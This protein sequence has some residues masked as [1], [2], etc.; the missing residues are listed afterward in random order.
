MHIRG[1]F[2]AVAV[3][4]GVA[5]PLS[6][7]APVS[8]APVGGQRWSVEVPGGWFHWSSPVIADIDGD[9]STDTAVGGLDGRLH[10][11]DA[12]GKA[13]P[14]WDGGAAAT[15]AVASSPAV[16][17][18]D[19]D[20]VNEIA[21]GVGSLEVA[22]Q[23]G[24]LDIFRADGSRRCSIQTRDA[25]QPPFPEGTAVFGAPAIGDVDGDGRAEVVF[26]SFDHH[27]RVVDAD[28]RLLGVFE[29]KD[30]IFSAP[31]LH[32]IDGDGAA[33]IFIG[34]DASRNSQTGES[35][36]GGYFRSLR[37]QAG[38][39]H[40][41][42]HRNLAQRWERRSTETFQSATAIGDIDGDGRL[43]AVTGSGAFW[44]RFHDQCADS[45]KVW[46][47][48]LDDGSDVAG[49]PKTASRE[50][51]F[52]SAPALGDIDGDG[53]IDVVVG[54]NDYDRASAGKGPNGGSVDVF[55]GDAAKARRSFVSPDVEVVAPPVIADVDG[56]GTPEVV[57]GT[58]SQIYA[59]GPDLSVAAS[60][61]AT[62][63]PVNHKAAVAVGRLG[64][65]WALVS[66]GFDGNRNGS[67][68][69]LDLAT[70]TSAP[71]PMHRGNA[72]R[73]GS[74]AAEP[75]PPASGFF[76]VPDTSPYA[77][78]V[79]WA[80]ERGVTTGC[81]TTLFCPAR[82]VTRAQIV[83]F[84]W[85]NVGKP[86]SGGERFDDVRP[87]A[88]YD[89]ATRWV[90]EEGITSGCTL[91]RFCPNGTATRAQVVTF[92][93]RAAGSPMVEGN[94]GFD[95]VVEDSYYEDAVTWAVREGITTGTSRTTFSPNLEVTR[96]QTVVFLFR[97]DQMSEMSV[98]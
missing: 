5:M 77:D 14:G 39:T 22:G 43:E 84:L 28:C 15:A 68:Q 56:T 1:T 2:L 57:V 25:A 82:N 12:T 38:Y 32:D 18:L 3:L 69:V 65:S 88:Y 54:T 45:N 93:W 40:P 23:R 72:R 24:A 95:D 75:E 30:S 73:T 62:S 64:T 81:T 85:R 35:L 67:V 36:N 66:T 83:V 60:N 91:T 49:W 29:S 79:G 86:S 34:V 19:G 17:D 21:V 20:G 52:L 42:G 53:R 96:G 47:F 74:V 50:T 11:W 78:A 46:A 80:A 70:P 41:D 89:T 58:A 94:H 61:L 27:I 98:R 90:R 59:L 37:W 31:A 48:H 51:T 76:D 71:W 13:L 9:G 63:P 26:G 87:D 16:A 6:A 7:S 8:A 33:E 55:Y 44:C 4:A 97:S 10:A 92:L